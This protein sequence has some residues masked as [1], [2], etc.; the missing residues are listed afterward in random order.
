MAS[1]FDSMKVSTSLDR[2]QALGT[3]LKAMIDA[4]DSPASHPAELAIVEERWNKFRL[5]ATG[6]AAAS[7]HD[8]TASAA[9]EEAVVAAIADDDNDYIRQDS[10][11]KWLIIKIYK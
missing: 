6:G 8:G 9:E 7:Q 10:P 2:F 1:L 3:L 5:A 11:M 4:G